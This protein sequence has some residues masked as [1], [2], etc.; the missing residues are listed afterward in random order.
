MNIIALLGW[1]E[2]V[3]LAV[4]IALGIGCWLVFSRSS[5]EKKDE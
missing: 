3:V 1:A 5:E 2:L 4:V